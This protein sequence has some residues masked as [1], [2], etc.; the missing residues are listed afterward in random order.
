MNKQPQSSLLRVEM[1]R[2]RMHGW[3]LV[4]GDPGYIDP[5]DPAV[6]EP[7]SSQWTSPIRRMDA[8]QGV[9]RASPRGTL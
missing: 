5:S 7:A 4:S 3:D 2:A 6:L 8:S 1:V 9:E